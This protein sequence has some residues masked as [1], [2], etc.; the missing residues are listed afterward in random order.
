MDKL[1]NTWDQFHLGGLEGQTEGDIRKIIGEGTS[2]IVSAMNK[3]LLTEMTITA[4]GAVVSALGIIS[5][6]LVYD[7]TK[8]PWIDPSKLI[9]LQLLAFVVFFV[10]LLFGWLEYKLVNRAF[11]SESVRAY[12]SSLL[13]NLKK[14]KRLFLIFVLALLAATYY[15]ELRYF[16]PDEDFAS[17]CLRIGGSVLLTSI[18]YLVIMMYYAKSFGP[19]MT[20]LTKYMEELEV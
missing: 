18:S 12:L 4:F 14:Y 10:L 15:L 7:P 1:K 20:K 13:V 5:F 6:Y 2:D 17:L 9:P 16:F 8:H 19:Y 3:K 11:T